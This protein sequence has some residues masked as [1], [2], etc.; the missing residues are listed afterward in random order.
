MRTKED[1]VK[2]VAESC[3]SY[4]ETIQAIICFDSAIRWD[5]NTRDYRKDTHF[6]P[7]RRMLRTDTTRV[8]PDIVVQVNKHYGVVGEVKITASNDRDFKHAE[9]QIKKYDDDLK[10]WKTETEKIKEHDLSLLVHLSN[11]AEA[12]RYFAKEKFSRKFNMISCARLDQVSI[13]YNIEKF[14]G[15]FLEPEID[16]KLSDGVTLPLE[17]VLDKLGVVKFSDQEPEYVEYTMNVIWMNILG[18]VTEKVAKSVGGKRREFVVVDCNKI[19]KILREQYSLSILDDNQPTIPRKA[20]VK[21]S[22]D[23]FVEIHLAEQDSKNR[24][25]YFI[26]H[27]TIRKDSM[28]EVFAKKCYKAKQKKRKS[29]EGQLEFEAFKERGAETKVAKDN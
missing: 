22:L 21:K 19:T 25:R 3:D 6:L 23:M 14:S 5:S 17:R 7:G 15:T 29:S 2:A 8:T 20:W 12:R 28:I 27:N 13:K 18:S 9:T 4:E 11:K 26:I 1:Y 10:G 16:K 24:D